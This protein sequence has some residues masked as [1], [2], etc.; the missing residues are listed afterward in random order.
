MAVWLNSTIRGVLKESTVHPS[1]SESLRALRE[2]LKV[3]VTL[4]HDVRVRSDA[5]RWEVVDQQGNPVGSYWMS[6]LDEGAK[7]VAAAHEEKRPTRIE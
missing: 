3:H 6:L 1:Q 2:A 4:G 7:G 5:K